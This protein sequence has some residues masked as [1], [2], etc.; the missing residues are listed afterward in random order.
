MPISEAPMAGIGKTMPFSRKISISSPLNRLAIGSLTS[1]LGPRWLVAGLLACRPFACAEYGRHGA[2][3]HAGMPRHGCGVKLSFGAL[4]EFE[5]AEVP[6]PDKCRG[7]PCAS[8]AAE[9]GRN[10][11]D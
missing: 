10:V 1:S 3:E 6:P 8:H 5:M 7:I 9:I 11:T 2:P 4:F